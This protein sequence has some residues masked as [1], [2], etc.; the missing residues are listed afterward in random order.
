M[1]LNRLPIIVSR[2]A[3]RSTSGGVLSQYVGARR[4]SAT[5][6]GVKTHWEPFD[7]AQGERLN[8][9]FVMSD[10]RSW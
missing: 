9:P 10:I 7:E 6:G 2:R 8:A 1:S 4:A 3:R 5:T